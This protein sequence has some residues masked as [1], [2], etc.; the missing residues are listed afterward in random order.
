MRGESLE[1]QLA[2]GFLLLHLRVTYLPLEQ[3]WEQALMW[4]V[5][6]QGGSVLDVQEQDPDPQRRPPWPQRVASGRGAGSGDYTVVVA[7]GVQVGVQVDT[8]GVVRLTWLASRGGRVWLMALLT[9]RGP[10]AAVEL[11]AEGG[12]LV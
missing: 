6:R 1:A 10:R 7:E 4:P 8:S 5:L 2:A 3:A 11:V 9:R 12:L